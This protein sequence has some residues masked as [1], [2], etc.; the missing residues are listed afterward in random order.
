MINWKGAAKRYRLLVDG[1]E[2]VCK[3]NRESLALLLSKLQA[4]KAENAKLRMHINEH[5]PGTLPPELR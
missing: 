3:L 5:A 2:V 1:Y 4:V